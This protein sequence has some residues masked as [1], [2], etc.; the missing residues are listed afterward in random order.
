M[1][2]ER[3]EIGERLLD[4]AY[5]RRA[6]GAG[7]ESLF[8]KLRGFG[9]CDHIRTERSLDD[10]M[11]AELFQSAYNLPELGICKLARNRRG[12]DCEHLIFRVVLALLYDVDR[13]EDKGLVG[14]RAEGTLINAGSAAYALGIVDRRRLVLVHV[15]GFDF[16]GVL[17]RAPSAYNRRIRAHLCA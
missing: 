14:Y 9:I 16:A 17:A 13:I 15:Y 10:R 4:I 1:R 7:E 11:E 12:N 3:Q 8:G 5:E 6:A 2:D